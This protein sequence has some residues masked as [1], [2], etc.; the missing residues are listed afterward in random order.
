MK[1]GGI[2]VLPFTVTE[3]SPEVRPYMTL[4]GDWSPD[5]E[6]HQ[7]DVAKG[8]DWLPVPHEGD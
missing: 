7:D 1:K 4:E 5:R 6:K 2:R 3:R 8:V